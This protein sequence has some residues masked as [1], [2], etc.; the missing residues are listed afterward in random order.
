MPELLIAYNDFEGNV[1]ERQLVDV[2]PGEP[3]YMQAFCLKKQEIRTFKLSRIVSAIVPETGEVVDIYDYLGVEAPAPPPPKKS[4]LPP[5]SMQEARAWRSKEK[6]ALWGRF[7]LRVVENHARQQF[8]RLFGDACFRCGA[9]GSLVIDHHIPIMLG[10][11]LEPGNLVALCSSCNSIKGD[12]APES[13]Y[14]QDDLRRLQ[15]FLDKQGPLFDFKFS[16]ERY[17]TNQREYLLSIGI[18][19]VLV[20]TVLEDRNHEWYVGE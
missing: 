12:L 20:E 17:H 15:P 7:A 6:S 14:T 5:A 10:G 2:R 16:W 4:Q 13:F 3:G 1:S 11:H 8:F 9:S 18:D 19:R